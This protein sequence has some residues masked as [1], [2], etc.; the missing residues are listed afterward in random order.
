MISRESIIQAIKWKKSPQYCAERLGISIEEFLFKKNQVLRE[1]FTV[2]QINDKL[3]KNEYIS[4][5]EEKIIEFSENLENGTGN[6]KAVSLS[7]PQSA[8][9]IEKLLKIDKN[10][11]KLS[12]YWNKEHKAPSGER[13]W[14]ISA[15][16]SKKKD[17]EISIEDM[18]NSLDK[19][20]QDKAYKPYR[21]TKTI[22]NEKA[23]FIYTSDKHIAASVDGNIAMFPNDYNGYSFEARLKRVLYEVQYLFMTFGKFEKIYI[24]DLGDRMDGLSGYTTRG[25]HKLPQNMSNRQA[26]ETAISVEKEFYDMI[27]QSEMANEY[28]VIANANS[29]HGGDFDYMVSRALEMYINLKYPDTETVIQEKFI[30][31]ITFGDHVI[32]LTHGKDDADMKHGLPLHLNDKTE[33]YINKYLMYHGINPEKCNVSLVKGDLHVD[34]SQTAYGFRYRNVLSLFGGSKWIGTNFGPT[35][36]GCSFDII[37]KES[38]RIFEHKIL[39]SKL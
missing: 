29:N 20:F 23:L 5:L 27:L 35:H 17:S 28:C 25:G 24:I 10:L 8:E 37:E 21:P 14:I 15:M 2:N 1:G 36:P 31:H 7:E 39:F 3:Q 38:D 34:N 11:W 18:Q 16:V 22:S 26:F 19:V 9:D 30:D 13:Y 6:I 4:Q 32:L 33:N 12:T